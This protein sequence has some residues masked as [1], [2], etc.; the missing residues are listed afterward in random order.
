MTTLG[1]THPTIHDDTG[2]KKSPHYFSQLSKKC[3]FSLKTSKSGKISSSIFKI[4][5]LTSLS[6]L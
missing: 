6:L 2:D 3:A 1:L 4:V 5:D